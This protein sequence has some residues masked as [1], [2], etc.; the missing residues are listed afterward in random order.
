MGD[1]HYSSIVQ[2]LASLKVV[3]DSDNR[4][5]VCNGSRTITQKRRRRPICLMIRKMKGKQKQQVVNKT[6]CPQT[7]EVESTNTS[8]SKKYQP[9]LFQD[10][11]GQNIVVKTLSNAVQKKKVAPLYLFHG[12]N[13]TG[14]TSAARIFAMALNCES[15]IHDKPCC[16]CKGCSRSLYTMELCSGNRISGFEKIRTLLQNTSFAQAITGLKVFIIEE[17]HSL[18]LEAWD[19]L[20]SLLEGPYG[21]NLVFL[22]IMVDVNSATGNI[23]SRCQ[24]FYF[25]KLN[26]EDIMKKLSTILFHERM[27]IEKEALKL[28]V[29]KSDGSLRDAENILDQLALLGP[30]ITTSMTQ[31]LVSKSLPPLKRLSIF[32]NFWSICSTLPSTY[33]PRAYH[34]DQSALLVINVLRI[35]VNYL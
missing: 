12:P 31:E 5:V 28:I 13:G 25:T 11:V 34:L 15:N 9:K 29:A 6:T 10:I 14:K 8:L 19:E 23:A 24:K 16:N 21:S 17:C 26:D 2:P 22:L 18:S 3:A 4:R 35:F 30:T 7:N 20:M 27:E 32:V 33:C 1:Y